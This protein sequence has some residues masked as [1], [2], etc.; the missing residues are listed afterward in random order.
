MIAEDCFSYALRFITRTDLKFE[1]GVGVQ[2]KLTILSS[3]TH[4]SLVTNRFEFLPNVEHKRR[5]FEKCVTIDFHIR[6]NK[7]CQVILLVNW[8]SKAKANALFIQQN[9]AFLCICISCKNTNWATEE[10]YYNHKTMP[11]LLYVQNKSNYSFQSHFKSNIFLLNIKGDTLKNVG[12]KII[13]LSI[14]E[15]RGTAFWTTAGCDWKRLA[16]NLSDV[17]TVI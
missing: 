3:F 9:V 2:P 15:H 11:P 5:Y 10:S 1:M 17:Y 4:P 7:F 12:N 6:R 13:L 8:I 14:D 16:Q